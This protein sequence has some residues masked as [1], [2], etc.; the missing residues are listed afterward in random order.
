MKPVHLH[1]CLCCGEDRF[2]LVIDLGEQVPANAVHDCL[3]EQRSYPLRMMRCLECGH[4]QLDRSVDPFELYD[5]YPYITG[6]SE[7]MVRHLRGLASV[8]GPHKRVLEIGCNDGTLLLAMRA[9]GCQVVGVE[10]SKKFNAIHEAAGLKVVNFLWSRD[11]AKKSGWYCDVVVGTN[12]FAH[13]R[14]PKDALLAC[15]EVLSP[16]GIAV[17]EV[18]AGASVIFKKQF[19]TIYHEHLSYFTVSSAREL[20]QGT[21]FQLIGAFPISVHG[22]SLRL[23]YGRRS[24]QHNIAT[25]FFMKE[26]I[27]DL[28]IAAGKEY[29]MEIQNRKEKLLALVK[30]GAVCVGASARATVMIQAWRPR[31]VAAIDDSQ[32]KAGRFV[33]GTRIPIFTF[34]WLARTKPQQVILGAWNL[35]DS[36]RPRLAA[37]LPGTEL[38]SYQPDITTEVL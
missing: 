4:M 17:F 10:P 21:P 37:M 13:L 3:E 27:G 33:A 14:D 11:F 18:H 15:D 19:D 2:D 34:D 24:G 16:G 36:L 9:M 26:S 5:D 32:F 22:G 29:S 28:A 20:A 6:V 25:A 30:P 23:V 1:S 7:S 38:I 12:V 35:Y 8:V 31:L